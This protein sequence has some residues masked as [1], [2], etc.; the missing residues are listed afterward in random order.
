MEMIRTKEVC[1]I[2]GISD[3][4]L[5]NYV[6]RGLLKVYQLRKHMPKRFKREDVETL[7][8]EMLGE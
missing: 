7:K 3:S 4:T 2:L 1:E 8:R 5:D 6:K